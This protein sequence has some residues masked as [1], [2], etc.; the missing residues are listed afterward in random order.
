MERKDPLPEPP[1]NIPGAKVARA[2]LIKMIRSQLLSRSSTE[3]YEYGRT[4]MD[5][6]L[7]LNQQLLNSL[8]Y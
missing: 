6:D 5:M 4:D 7:L 3:C 1:W 8:N 2:E